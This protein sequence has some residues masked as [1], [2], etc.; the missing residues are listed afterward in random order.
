MTHHLPQYFPAPERFDV[1]RYSADRK[2]HMQPNVY[3]PYGLG[4]HTCLGASTADM[5]YLI[6]TAVLFRH[7]HV[8]MQPPDQDLHVVM[9]PL[10]SPDDRFRIAITGTRYPAP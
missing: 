10:P 7:F 4:A 3:C 2:E 8:E 6:V 5:L 1:G 9:N